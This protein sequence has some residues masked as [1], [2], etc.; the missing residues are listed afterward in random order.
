M[1]VFTGRTKACSVNRRV[2]SKDVALAVG[3]SRTAVSLVLN[4]RA[5]GEI[6]PVKQELIRQTAAELG[7]VPNAAAVNLQRQS[8]AT[9]GLITD[10]IA[11]APFA[12]Q[13]ID[14]ATTAAMQ[15]GFMI[16]TIDTA[17]HDDYIAGAVE[18][19]RARDVD[20]IIFAAASVRELELPPSAYALPLVLA[21]AI[22]SGGRA[23]C[24]VPDDR[25]GERAA[26]RLALE[27]GHTRICFITGDDDA[28]ATTERRLG[29][30]AEL[31]AAGLPE[32]AMSIRAGAY[33]MRSHHEVA[34]DLLAGPDR[35]TAILC[36]ND[37]GASGVV[38]A[39]AQLGL[40]V[41]EDLSVIGFDDEQFFASD[42]TPGL[43]TIGLPHR[44]M[45]DAAARSLLET[46]GA[47]ANQQSPAVITIPCN[48]VE[49]RSLAGPPAHL[50]L[51]RK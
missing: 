35:P 8:T 17:F 46:I 29:F 3:V 32:A 36:A 5:D 18:T 49:R 31:A 47:S 16:L 41:P 43:T 21:N 48:V 50:R 38:L 25:G 40:S 1:L 51:A 14:G 15:A 44:E 34:L 22:D 7:Y 28:R 45:G 9:I 6:D 30:K 39:A 11:S 10:E 37:R 24:F 20:G 19:L 23:Q 2:T 26:A 27:A 42:F 33:S 13:L 12:G 4:N